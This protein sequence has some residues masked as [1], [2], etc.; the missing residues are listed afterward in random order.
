MKKEHLA[1]HLLRLGLPLGTA[2][3]FA[4]GAHALLRNL[5]HVYR[6]SL[7][8]SPLS[9][10]LHFKGESL[11]GENWTFLV[12]DPERDLHVM[13]TLAVCNPAD[14]SYLSETTA[15]YLSFAC[16]YRGG[17]WQLLDRYPLHQF[18]AS[19]DRGE[20]RLG[21]Y[22]DPRCFFKETTRDGLT[23]VESV[24]DLERETFLS[25]NYPGPLKDIS[26]DFRLRFEGAWYPDAWIDQLRGVG[27]YLK[28]SGVSLSC[29]ATDIRG[30]LKINDS[31]FDLNPEQSGSS[32][33]FLL[34]RWGPFP[35]GPGQSLT[36]VAG[37]EDASSAFLACR[38]PGDATP[39]HARRADP[40]SLLF[41]LH[42]GAGSSVLRN[43]PLRHGILRAESASR[44]RGGSAMPRVTAR[45][46]DRGRDYHAEVIPDEAGSLRL[47]FP[48]PTGECIHQLWSPSSRLVLLREASRS[49]FRSSSEPD[50]S[51]DLPADLILEW[52]D[53]DW[54]DQVA[55]MIEIPIDLNTF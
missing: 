7:V 26:W 41:Y 49:R 43:N 37:G 15:A 13:I 6:G 34:H 39:R 50:D 17:G 4:A 36:C 47:V 42:D 1:K 35:G 25:N 45:G 53:G 21:P 11:Y 27:R 9:H 46:R 55:D 51:L 40:F 44:D 52:A 38:F 48:G 16:R 18:H 8:H 22:Q 54:W 20:V 12:E 19:E 28:P 23:L 2:A 30:G 24:G 33:A 5:D 10:A 32:R 31:F 29:R 14:T 3:G